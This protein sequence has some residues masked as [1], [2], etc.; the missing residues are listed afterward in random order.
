MAQVQLSLD[1]R[2]SHIIQTVEGDKK[3]KLIPLVRQD[4]ALLDWALGAPPNQSST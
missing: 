2:I 4:T 3:N 1:K